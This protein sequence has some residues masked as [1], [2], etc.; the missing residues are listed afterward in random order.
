LCVC[1]FNQLACCSY[2]CNS[3]PNPPTSSH[4]PC[5]IDNCSILRAHVSS[6][7]CYNR[8]H[9]DEAVPV[10]SSA[11]GKLTTTETGKLKLTACWRDAGKKSKA[12]AKAASRS[13]ASPIKSV[14]SGSTSKGRG[15]KQ[16]GRRRS[17]ESKEDGNMDMGSEV[18]EE[19]EPS[20]KR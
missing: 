10:L 2:Q 11:E 3:V 15:T 9:C 18:E 7:E 5:A 20:P 1:T 14:G 19:D 6:N 17:R 16:A 12:K 4:C 8:Q 13:P